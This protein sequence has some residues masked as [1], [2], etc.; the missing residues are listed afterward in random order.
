MHVCRHP[1]VCIYLPRHVI[2]TRTHANGFAVLGSSKRLFW[3]AHV[4]KALL[5]GSNSRRVRNP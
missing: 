4:S 2:M 3:I 1:Y 5:T